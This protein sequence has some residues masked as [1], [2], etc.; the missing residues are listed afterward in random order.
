MKTVRL[1]ARAWWK[2]PDN[3]ADLRGR[4]SDQVVGCCCCCSSSTRGNSQ[5]EGQT[6]TDRRTE[7]ETTQKRTFYR[8][9]IVVGRLNKTQK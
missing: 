7:T 2:V 6:H 3:L 9:L 1:V 8:R 5:G 4:Q